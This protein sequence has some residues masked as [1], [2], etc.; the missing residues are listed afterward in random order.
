MTRGGSRDAVAG[1]APTGYLGQGPKARSLMRQGVRSQ[2]FSDGLKWILSIF[3]RVFSPSNCRGS[4]FKN[5]NFRIITL[6]TWCQ[7]FQNLWYE[8]SQKLSIERFINF[9]SMQI[10]FIWFVKVSK[11]E[12]NYHML[13]TWLTMSLF[14]TLTCE[15]SQ[16][17][18][19]HKRKGWR[20][21]SKPNC[22]QKWQ[23]MCG[24]KLDFTNDILD[25]QNNIE[26][27]FKV[28]FNR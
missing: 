14:Q 28:T 2:R 18:K 17:L 25:S 5:N 22:S 23:V 16:K 21:C 19:I 26:G 15:M 12:D 7:V 10:P 24:Q 4:L 1:G 27:K 9:L 13:Y 11:A 6:A 3:E 8:M 20:K